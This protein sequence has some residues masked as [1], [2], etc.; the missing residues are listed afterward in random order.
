MC[1]DMDEKTFFFQ[2]ERIWRWKIYGL[3][4]I[5]LCKRE[6]WY[7]LLDNFNFLESSLFELW[8]T[9]VRDFIR[10]ET[11]YTV[12]FRFSPQQRYKPLKLLAV[13]LLSVQQYLRVMNFCFVKLEITKLYWMDVLFQIFRLYRSF[14]ILESFKIHTRALLK[15]N[16]IFARTR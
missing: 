14:T 5:R 4:L 8:L 7:T 15:C 11:F 2:G 10:D 16:Q 9:H 1:I 13:I 6:I 3:V 12:N